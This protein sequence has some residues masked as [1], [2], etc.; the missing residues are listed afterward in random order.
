MTDRVLE[1]GL[2]L[3]EYAFLHDLPKID[4]V[5]RVV[6]RFAAIPRQGRPRPKVAIFGDLYARDNETLNQNLVRTIEA[7]GGE[8]ITTPYNEYIKTIAGL[9][10]RKWMR[11]GK[12]L[13]VLASGSLLTTIQLMEKKY[14]EEFA[15]LLGPPPDERQGPEAEEI[16]KK[17]NV[18]AYHTGETMDNLLN[19][20]HVLEAHPDLALF[21]HASPAFCCPGLVTEALGPQIERITGVPMVSVTYDGTDTAMNDVVIPYLKFPRHRHGALVPG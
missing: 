17:F 5:K 4:V 8:V 14:T 6:D 12:Y 3:F 21:V 16:L 15:R 11:E 7:N 1:E 9:Y 10:F 20:F 18:S 19:I 2:I 13:R